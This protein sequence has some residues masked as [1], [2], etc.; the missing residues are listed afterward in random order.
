MHVRTHARTH[1]GGG[2]AKIKEFTLGSEDCCYDRKQ[3]DAIMRIMPSVI[4]WEVKMTGE[5][6]SAPGRSGTGPQRRSVLG[7]SGTN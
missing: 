5:I 7:E 2:S 4:R 3:H 1:G 6:A